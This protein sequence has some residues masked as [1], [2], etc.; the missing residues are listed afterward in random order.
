MRLRIDDPER[1]HPLPQF[2]IPPCSDAV[3]PVTACLRISAILRDA[4]DEGVW[5]R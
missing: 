4:E 5:R 2:R 1:R 3:R